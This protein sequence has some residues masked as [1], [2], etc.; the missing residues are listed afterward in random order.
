[1]DFLTKGGDCKLFHVFPGRFK[2]PKKMIFLWRHNYITPSPNLIILVCLD[3]E[4]PYLPTDTKNQVHR[5]FSSDNLGTGLQQP[6][7]LDVLQTIVWLGQQWF[8]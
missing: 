7:W 6:H 1:M 3:R 4:G 8:I 2:T 5:G